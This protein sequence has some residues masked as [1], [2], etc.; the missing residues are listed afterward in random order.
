MGWG[1]N[2]LIDDHPFTGQQVAIV[3][4]FLNTDLTINFITSYFIYLS[5]Y[6][7]I[8]TF[9]INR[10]VDVNHSLQ[11]SSLLHH[12]FYLRLP[13]EKWSKHG[14]NVVW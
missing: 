6:L 11:S 14:T 4:G 2:F 7:F 5:I 8:Y 13:N 3:Y 1:R 9:I 10:V 12:I